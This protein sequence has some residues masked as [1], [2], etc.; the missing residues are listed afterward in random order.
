MRKS[1]IPV[2]GG[3]ADASAPEARR[4]RRRSAKES[5]DETEAVVDEYL[6]VVRTVDSRKC[7]FKMICFIGANNTSFGRYG[8]NVS[9]LFRY[10]LRNVGSYL[11]GSEIA[12][13]YS[14]AYETGRTHGGEGCRIKYNSCPM[15]V[16]DLVML[17]TN[18]S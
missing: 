18:F 7:V 14:R 6:E 17:S 15:S 5:A 4:R 12:S 11:S 3:T 13:D 2:R 9:T 1:Q 16:V 10:I 8:D